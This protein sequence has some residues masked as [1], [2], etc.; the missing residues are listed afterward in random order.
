MTKIQL[1]S[2]VAL[3]FQSLSL[4]A[5]PMV[6][7][8]IQKIAFGSCAKERELQ[9]IWNQ[10]AKNQP[11]IFLFIGDNQYADLQDIK[12]ELVSTPVTD[13]NRIVEAY[14]TL[15]AIPEFAQFKQTVPIL[16]TWD[17]HDYGANDAGTDY[18]LKHKSQQIFLDFFGFDKT[19]PIRKQQGVYQSYIYGPEG[20]RVQV[21]LLDTRY[22]RDEI[23]PKTNK[24]DPGRYVAT[25]DTT[26]TILGETQWQW[27]EQQLLKPAEVRIIASSIQVVAYQHGWET[28]GTMPHERQRLYDLIGKTKANGVVIVS[29]DRHLMEVSV[30]KGQRGNQVPYP[31]WDFT[32]SGLTDN[33]QQVNEVND[34]RIGPVYRGTNFGELEIMWETEVE[35]SKIK[36]TARDGDGQILTKQWVSITALQVAE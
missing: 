35:N 13:A 31:I 4:A 19:D 6:P 12:G 32:S 16:A 10:I 24:N 14:D 33:I 18:P 9:P 5:K 21:I 26:R 30:D 27:L 20:K 17:D 15:A 23:T 22:H 34:F 2:V 8:V 36:F 11:D 7:D 3:L 1:L 28:W 29:G 25:S